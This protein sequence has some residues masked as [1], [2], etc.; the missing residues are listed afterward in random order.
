M[1]SS[2]GSIQCSM[3]IIADMQRMQ[4]A[5]PVI[6]LCLAA[7]KAAVDEGMQNLRY[8]GHDL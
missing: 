6:G 4:N 5:A 7:S 8:P 1:A 2:C 3:A